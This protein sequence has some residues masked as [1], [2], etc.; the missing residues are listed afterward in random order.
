MITTLAELKKYVAVNNSLNIA[1]LKPKLDQAATDYIIPK[2]SQALWDDIATKYEADTLSDPE[3]VLLS[4]I[5]RTLANFALHLNIPISSLEWGA[6]GFTQ[7]DSEHSKAADFRDVNR[8]SKSL[9]LT[10]WNTLET[11]VL[12]LETFRDS[13]TTYNTSQER[14]D[15]VKLFINSAKSY[16]SVYSQVKDAYTF[17]ALRT[18]IEDVEYFYIQSEI[19][20]ETLAQLKLKIAYGG[21]SDIESK[22]IF[23]AQK[24]VA[25]QSISVGL[26]QNVVLFSG[27]NLFVHEADNSHRTTKPPTTQQIEN[28]VLHHNRVSD[29]YLCDLR[30]HLIANPTAFPNYEVV[31]DTD[32]TAVNDKDSAFYH[33]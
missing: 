6:K 3:T 27:A 22:A 11:L 32:T 17:E 7:A 2:V 4:N 5:Q 16:R 21:A 26:E 10:G 30:D 19:G 33:S 31:D 1:D 15:N 24:A 8:L 12:H 14:K 13:F 9:L 28:T 29:K 18:I 25:Y 20:N 23:L